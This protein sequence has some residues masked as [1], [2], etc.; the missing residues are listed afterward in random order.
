[1]FESYVPA[2]PISKGLIFRD[3]W[4]RYYADI[5]QVEIGFGAFRLLSYW[6]I[7]KDIF[8][9]S[10]FNEPQ[11]RWTTRHE[12]MIII[13]INSHIYEIENRPDYLDITKNQAYADRV[14]R[15]SLRASPKR[16]PWY[17]RILRKRS[18]RSEYV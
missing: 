10:P 13:P 11:L 8:N 12:S 1:M 18:E 16:I 9:D 6:E 17:V 4:M 14:K 15:E 5:D 3:G 7:D 2:D